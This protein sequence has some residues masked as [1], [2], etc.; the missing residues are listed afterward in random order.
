MTILMKRLICI[1]LVSL[2]AYGCAPSKS[3]VYQHAPQPQP[4]TKHKSLDWQ[5]EQVMIMRYWTQEQR[6]EF[7]RDYVYS[8][9]NLFQKNGDTLTEK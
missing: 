4:I 8:E 9:V 3:L 2:T 6:D 7:R 5:Q 1:S